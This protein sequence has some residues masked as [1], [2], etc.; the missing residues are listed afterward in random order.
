M[1]GECKEAF[2]GPEITNHT[3]RDVFNDKEEV[4]AG[5]GILKHQEQGSNAHESHDQVHGSNKA[6]VLSLAALAQSRACAPP[7]QGVLFE[8][9]GSW[10]HLEHIPTVTVTFVQATFVLV[11]FVHIRNIFTGAT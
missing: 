9:T 4:N 3:L 6:L 11:T 1:E 10:E 8:Q 7:K 2:G 5:Y